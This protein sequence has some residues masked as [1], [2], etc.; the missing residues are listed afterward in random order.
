MTLPDMYCPGGKLTQSGTAVAA[1]YPEIN[2]ISCGGISDVPQLLDSDNGEYVLP[3]WNSNQGEIKA[4][5]YVW[6]LI[7]DSKIKI[8]DV[9]AKSIEFWLVARSGDI[10]R[11]GKIGSVVVAETQCSKF[12]RDQGVKLEPYSLSDVAYEA[13]K[14]GALLDGVLVAP[15]QGENDEG[16]EVVTKQTANK[17]NFTSFVRL[18][19][20]N[21]TN[22][23]IAPTSSWLTGVTIDSL[24]GAVLDEGQ[25]S[26]LE[27]VFSDSQN[28][29]EIPK[30][31][32][33][34][35]RTAKVGL[36]FEGEKF[37]SGDFLNAE[38]LESGN[39]LV[40]EDVG[41]LEQA[42]S[43]EVDALFSKEFPEMKQD[44]FILHCG[45]NTFLFACPPLGM[46]THGYEREAVEP[47]VRLY[48]DKI[49]EFIDNNGKCSSGEKDF[50]N[51]HKNS[52]GKKRSEFIEFKIIKS[53]H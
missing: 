16:Y 8:F 35:K 14:K 41:E 49:F 22:K 5:E 36:L 53:D 33:V 30:L 47:V 44:D 45:V 52:W 28:M 2:I 50:F 37:S 38:E 34:F 40:H 18:A 11:H 32:F 29:E 1:R 43:R 12:L 31:I 9:W 3:I 10:S 17:N 24:A 27:Q 20:S 26:F 48:I 19:P 39:I 15:G 42:Y 7:E 25:V 21:S 4:S 23:N 13:Y 6:D 46:Y 51:R